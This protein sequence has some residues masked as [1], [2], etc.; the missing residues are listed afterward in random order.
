MLGA[1][2]SKVLAQYFQEALVRGEGDLV[3]LT[4]HL[5]GCENFGRGSHRR[6]ILADAGQP[7]S[8][9]IGTWS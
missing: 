5:Q 8:C 4:V 2:E 9:A 7:C 3:L 6:Q 1:G